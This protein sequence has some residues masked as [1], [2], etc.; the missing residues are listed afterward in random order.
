[1]KLLPSKCSLLVDN[2]A[3]F[4]GLASV[5]SYAV[6]GAAGKLSFFL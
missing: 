4:N 1:M 5:F 3:A 6:K 2:N